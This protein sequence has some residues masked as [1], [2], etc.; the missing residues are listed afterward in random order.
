MNAFVLIHFGDKPKYLEL[1][2]YTIIMLKQN[3]KNDIVY[4]YSINDTPK[5]FIEIIKKYCDNVVPYD[6]KGITYDIKNFKSLYEHFNTLR[7]CNFLFSYQLTQYK[8]IC[9]IESDMIILKNIDDIFNLNTPSILTYYDIDKIMENYKINIDVKKDLEEC[10][11]KSYVN[12]GVLL[13]K[14]S[15]TKFNESIKNIKNIIENNCIYPN[16]TLFLITNKT[17]YNL[18][19]KYN[20]VQFTLEKYSDKFKINMIDYL[21]IVHMNAK[22]H[23]HIDIIKDKWLNKLKNRKDKKLLYYFISKFKKEYYD[24]FNKNIKFIYNKNLLNIVK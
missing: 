10:S 1:E 21:S 16:E 11:K 13:L 9:V 12:G 8:K 6:D 5:Y 23:K 7:T 18:P 22:E 24:K 3:S 17:I 4:M 19:Y 15:I 2:I 20:G 14:P